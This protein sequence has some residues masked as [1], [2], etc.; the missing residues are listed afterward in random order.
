MGRSPLGVVDAF[1][2]ADTYGV[3]GS[4][5][6]VPFYGQGGLG[7]S[8][9]FSTLTSSASSFTAGGAG[10]TPVPETGVV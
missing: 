7:V 2:I 6:I 4:Y 10:V 5:G 9:L 3:V 8:A 1:G